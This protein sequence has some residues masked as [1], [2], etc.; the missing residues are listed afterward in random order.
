MRAA[1]KATSP[2]WMIA[3]ACRADSARVRQEIL[4]SGQVMRNA[5]P[6][7]AAKEFAHVARPFQLLKG[8]KQ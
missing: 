8:G 2:L 1:E 5:P 3:A 4:G 6:H 7:D